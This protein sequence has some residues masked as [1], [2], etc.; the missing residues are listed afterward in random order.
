MSKESTRHPTNGFHD[1]V[2]L[3]FRCELEKYVKSTEQQIL[4]ESI[5][6]PYDITSAIRLI[7]YFKKYSY[8][9]RILFL[10]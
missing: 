2:V 6:F 5:A 4:S 7:P 10:Q 8:K 9:R 1:I 3:Q